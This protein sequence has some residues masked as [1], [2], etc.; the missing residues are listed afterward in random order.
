MAGDLVAR[1]ARIHNIE[2]TKQ[3]RDR[4]RWI[5]AAQAETEAVETQLASASSIRV[6]SGRH[7]LSFRLF[8]AQLALTC[9]E[10]PMSARQWR[11]LRS[12]ALQHGQLLALPDTLRNPLNSRDDG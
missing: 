6:R 3:H 8:A 5:A 10:V 12:S 2:V 4:T 9:A 7:S 11:S 1:A